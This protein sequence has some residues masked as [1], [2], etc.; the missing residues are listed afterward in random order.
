MFFSIEFSIEI[1]IDF[2]TFLEFF[3][4]I[5][6]A[7]VCLC[8][9]LCALQ[10][11]CK[12]LLIGSVAKKGLSSPWKLTPIQPMEWEGCPAHETEGYPAYEKW[13]QSSPST[14]WGCPAH[15]GFPAHDK[16]WGLSSPWKLGA[17]QP[18]KTE[19]YPAHENWGLSSPWKLGA[20]QPMKT[21]GYPA[22]GK[23]FFSFSFLWNSSLNFC[24]TLYVTM[25][26]GVPLVQETPICFAI[27]MK[28]SD[29]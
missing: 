9:C 17:I 18:M 15:E 24:S 23:Q 10:Q 25:L 27:A 28:L 19:G 26:A 14:N 8:M 21:E 5:I 13:R 1:S 3:P 6:F 12:G 7:H 29:P 11:W 20:I 2:L 16:N 22:H 4:I